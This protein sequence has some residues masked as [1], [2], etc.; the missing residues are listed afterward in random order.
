MRND[1]K[2]TDAA[3]QNMYDIEKIFK[4]V[5]WTLLGSL[6]TFIGLVVGIYFLARTADFVTLHWLTAFFAALAL[7][8]LV[9][10]F[11]LMLYIGRNI[12]LE[13]GKGV[14]H[15]VTHGTEMAYQHI[16][17]VAQAAVRMQQSIKNTYNSGDAQQV[18]LF[19]AETRRQ[20][21]ALAD[22]KFLPP[23]MPVTGQQ[24]ENVEDRKSSSN[25]V[26]Y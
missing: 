15:G 25:L 9:V 1:M 6:V 16:G 2:G 22:T 20:M 8:E 10:G 12:G 24:P 14:I 17:G 19:D 23:N 21:Q 7:V 4:V 3:T 18:P 13:R 11:P 5:A 26:E